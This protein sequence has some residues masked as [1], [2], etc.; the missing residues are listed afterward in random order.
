MRPIVYIIGTGP[1]DPGLI[2]AR[3]LRYLASADVVLYD[4]LVHPRLLRYPRQDAEKID[5]GLAAPQPLAQE[6]ISYLLVEKA[7][8]GKVVARLK[9]GDPYTFD[10]GGQEALFL[11]EHGVPFEVVPGIPAAIG[12]TSYAG[13]PLTYPGGGDSVTFVRG[14]EDE[15]TAPPNVDWKSLAALGG[16]LVCYAGPRQLPEILKALVANGFDRQEP[17]AIVYDGTLPTQRT[18]EGTLQQLI[19]MKNLRTKPAILVVGRVAGLRQH[20]RWF[21]E[22]P[23]FGK[24]IVVT[25]SREQSGDL[26]EL[27]E[28]LGAEPI[29]AP[30]IRVA[31]PEDFGPL[32]KAVADA[33]SFDW[34]VFTSANAVDSFMRRLA[35][36]DGDIRDLKGIRLAAIGPATAERLAR[37][38]LKV[39]LRPE[40]SRAEAIVQALR[41]LGSLSGKRFLLPRADIARDVLPDELRKNGAEV[42]E[43][44]AYHTVLAEIER[45]GDPDIYRMLLEKRVDVVTF[46][47]ASTVKNF[48]QIFGAEQAPDLLNATKVAAIG[49]V[50]AEA[51]EQYGIKTA[52]MPRQYTIP[53]LVDAIVEHF[54]H[55]T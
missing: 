12:T 46:T 31:P 42:V 16:T 21:D 29:E 43:V 10:R 2:S 26:V 5:V 45:E 53:A 38:G 51:A 18:T 48:V 49:P 17:A 20:L 11:H 54:N 34:I 36:G 55:P 6:A 8:E 14:H 50:T 39:D 15:S 41:D 24:R 33:S 27:L 47:S 52:I 19:E 32:D 13:V 28:S 9:W 37:H 3:G 4:H 25:R 30:M 7:R 22:R 1:G 35:G 23:L 44:T 40:E